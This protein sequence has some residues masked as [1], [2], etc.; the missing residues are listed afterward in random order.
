M[1][2]VSAGCTFPCLSPPAPKPFSTASLALTE[3]V[4]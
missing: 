1:E 3:A 2:Y 4:I